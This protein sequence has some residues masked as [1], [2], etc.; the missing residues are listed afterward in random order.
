MREKKAEILE[1]IKAKGLTID[2][3]AEQMKFDPNILK[4]YLA[5]DDYPIPS[6]IIEKIESVLAA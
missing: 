5:S 4:L 2:A 3:V 6:R 1:K